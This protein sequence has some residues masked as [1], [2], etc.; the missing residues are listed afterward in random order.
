MCI[1]DRYVTDTIISLLEEHQDSWDKPW[2]GVDCDNDYARNP[3]T[4]NYYRGI[5]QIILGFTMIR[6]GYHR[7]E[8]STF[9][10]IS[11][12][13]GSV[14]KGQKST[15]IIFYKTAYIDQDKKYYKPETVKNMS[16]NQVHAKGIEAIPILKIYRV[17]NLAAQTEGLDEHYYKIEPQGELKDFEKDEAAENLIRATGATIIERRSNRAYYDRASDSIVLPMRDQFK[18]LKE[19]FYATALHETVHW[20]GHPERLNREFGERFGDS[21]YAKEELIAE[22]GSAFLSAHL[23]FTQTITNNASYINSWLGI[24]K[25]DE[26][27]IIA[28]SAAAQKAADYIIGGA[29]CADYCNQSV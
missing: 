14:I 15:P 2:I 20:T 19:H 23:G 4:Q 17:F 22:L 12:L 3:A 29:M 7:N 6:K 28:A 10:Q 8:W 9:N 16:F 13:N 21:V 26:K 25:K 18:G 27:A 11:S 5:N 1:R 24:M